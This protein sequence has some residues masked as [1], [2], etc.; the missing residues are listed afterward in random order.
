MAGR[1]SDGLILQLADPDLIRWMIGLMRDA[2]EAAGRDPASIRVQAAAPAHVGRIEEC[3]EH[4]R[5]FPGLVSGHVVELVRRFPD[6]QLPES[7]TGYLRDGDGGGNQRGTEF[8]SPDA[9]SV[10]DDLVNRFT[11]VGPPEE[12]VRR[13]L[14]LSRLG[15]DQFNLYLMSGDEEEQ[16]EAYGSSIIPALRATPGQR[17]SIDTP[18]IVTDTTRQ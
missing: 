3:R 13:L 16:L 1:I 2:A 14:D 15:V 6:D 7:L 10:G 4:V 18:D 12:H 8:G 11:V 9:A 5:W 17:E